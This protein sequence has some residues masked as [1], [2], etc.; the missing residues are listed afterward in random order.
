MSTNVNELKEEIKSLKQAHMA[1][2][3]ERNEVK[4]VEE[5]TVAVKKTRKSKAVA[6]NKGE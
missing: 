4:E 2:K 5:A 3:E 1:I 6:K